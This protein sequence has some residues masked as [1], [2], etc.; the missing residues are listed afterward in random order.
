MM[1]KQRNKSKGFYCLQKESS[2]ILTDRVNRVIT[3]PVIN[4]ALEYIL[5]HIEEELT[6]EDVA[7][8]C[9]FSKYYF[10]RLFK[11]QTGES[12]YAYIRR[13]RLE[14]SAF[15]LKSERERRITEIGADYGYSASNYSSA[16][17]K[18]YRMSP[19]D[20]RKGSGQRTKR[21]PFFHHEEW[22]T[23]NF[24]DCDALISVEQV[25]DYHVIYERRF[26]NYE[27]LSRNWNEFIG[28]YQEYVTGKTLFLE[29]TYD[30]PT[31][32]A[33]DNCLYDV[34]MSVGND[35]LLENTETIEGGRCAVYHFKGHAKHIYAAYQTIF[36]VW[37]PR[38]HYEIDTE[39]NIFDIYH[40]ID[41]ETM[42][43]ELNICLP[44][45]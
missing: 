29:R 4:K 2:V 20:F 39:R 32:T 10:E 5:Y 25:P 42:Y 21:H 9:H 24:E 22:K 12:V 16:F 14:Q 3:N 43:M 11:K 23:G 19:A 45:K 6:L 34:C 44:V 35:C 41:C 27:S 37:L 36:L 7:E 31:V 40:R 1:K 18:H 15:R 17:K 26:G 8:H 28:K 38:K 33:T 13:A 30:D